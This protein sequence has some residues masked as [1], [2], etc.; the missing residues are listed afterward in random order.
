MLTD[1]A[2]SAALPEF[3]QAAKA[4]AK[5]WQFHFVDQANDRMHLSLRPE[6]LEL[7]VPDR[8]FK[9]LKIDFSTGA[10]G[11]RQ[12]HLQHELLIKAC[13]AKSSRLRIVD[14]TAGLGRD[15]F[16]LA[17]AGHQVLMLE[18]SPIMAALLEDA[19]QRLEKNSHYDL[20]LKFTDAK[21]WVSNLRSDEHPDVILCDPMHPTRQKSALVKKELRII[22]ELV[23]VDE[24]ADEL[25]PLALNCAKR[26]VVKRP[27][28]AEPLAGIKPHH[29]I[30]AVT[31]ERIWQKLSK[32]RRR[33]SLESSG[34]PLSHLSTALRRT[35]F[36]AIWRIT[37]IDES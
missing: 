20:T 29:Q 10:M 31:T 16:L 25:L 7:V 35:L 13:G 1:I 19:I 28:L 18:R 36:D 8:G 30:T 23:G 33:V 32:G 24:D 21:T 37:C 12:Q 5:R 22:R 14:L 15:A 26:V 4:L 6:G 27:R 9:P 3:V 2:I 17:A 34:S 11:Y